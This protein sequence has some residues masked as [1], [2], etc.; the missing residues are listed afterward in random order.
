MR[1]WR[2]ERPDGA[3]LRAALRAN[4]PYVALTVALCATRL[5]PPLRDLLKP[6]WA[7]RPFDNQPAFAPLYA[8]GFWLVSIGL[9]VVWLARAPLGRV[10]AETGRA[11][12]RS[13]AVTLAFVVMAEFYVGSGMAG[14]IGVSVAR[15]KAENSTRPLS[16]AEAV[17]DTTDL[18]SGVCPGVVT[19]VTA[20]G[21]I[22]IGAACTFAGA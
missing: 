4:A 14:T 20:F 22:G 8:P 6:L 17:G 7:M 1:F 18:S 21:A 19:C 12:W 15:R 11:A 5:V 13:C 16:F 10:L 9:V 2:D 3:R